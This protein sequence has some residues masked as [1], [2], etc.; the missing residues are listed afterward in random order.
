MP[1]PRTKPR[2]I[3]VKWFFTGLEGADDKATRQ[4]GRKFYVFDCPQGLVATDSPERA[5]ELFDGPDWGDWVAVIAPSLLAARQAYEAAHRQ[6]T[7]VGLMERSPRSIG[8]DP[9]DFPER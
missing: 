4:T 1:T 6:W 9:A 5:A 8:L 7:H 3:S 2:P